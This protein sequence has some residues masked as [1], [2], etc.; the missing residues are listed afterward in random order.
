MFDAILL[1]IAKHQ[2]SSGQDLFRSI[3]G[4]DSP[5]SDLSFELIG[6]IIDLNVNDTRS[7]DIRT[8]SDL[9]IK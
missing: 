2:V 6:R 1:P 5:T 7:V 3:G 8:G 9:Y 4:E